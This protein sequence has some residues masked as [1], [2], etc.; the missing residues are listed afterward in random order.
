[1]TD[2]TKP[3]AGLRVLELGA[4]VAAPYCGMLLA[5]MGA[6]VIKIEPPEGDM[7]RQFAPFI[8]GESAFFL[9]VNRSKRSVCLDLK[10][11]RA[12]EWVR[13][14]ASKA[15]IV[16]HNFRTGVAERL[17][18]SYSDLKEQNPGLVYCAV[19]GFGPEGPLATRPAIDLIFQA[20]S[21]MLAMWAQMRLMFMQQRPQRCVS[22]QR[23]CSVP[24]PDSGPRC[25]S[26]S[27][28]HFLHCRHAGSQ[29]SLPQELSHR[30]WDPV[31]L[32]L[33][34]PTSIK[35]RMATLFSPSSTRSTGRSFVRCCTS[36]TSTRIRDSVVTNHVWPKLASSAVK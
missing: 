23:W 9:S 19:S 4:L 36:N 14:M 8:N 15:D 30:A 34:P 24:T 3:L 29:V 21:G 33:R 6:E 26:P 31:H 10:D 11:Q 22:R 12:L 20:E 18:L 28:M 17:G 27:V 35:L 32:S 16:I 25:M 1:M 13:V 5:D 7:A 2:P